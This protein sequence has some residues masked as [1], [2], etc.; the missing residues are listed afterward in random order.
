MPF[1]TLIILTFMDYVRE[2]GRQ[3][4]R[5]G[6]SRQTTPFLPEEPCDEKLRQ[7]KWVN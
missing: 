7:Q 6:D 5:Q 1:C 3:E 2:E 4:G